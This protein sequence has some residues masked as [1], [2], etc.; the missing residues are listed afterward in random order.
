MT[1]Y[2]EMPVGVGSNFLLEVALVQSGADIYEQDVFMENMSELVTEL[3]QQNPYIG[4]K[5]VMDV[6]EP[7]T[8]ISL[9]DGSETL[10]H[11]SGDPVVCT[12]IDFSPDINDVNGILCADLAVEVAFESAYLKGFAAKIKA[13]AIRNMELEEISHPLVDEL[14]SFRQAVE[15]FVEAKRQ[16]PAADFDDYVDE[17]VADIEARSTVMQAEVELLI[18]DIAEIDLRRLEFLPYWVDQDDDESE[19]S[20]DDL[21]ITNDFRGIVKGRVV[22][23]QAIDDGDESVGLEVI[24]ALDPDNNLS[25]DPTYRYALIAVS[26]IS[27]GR[28]LSGPC[29]N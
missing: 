19:I 13:E 28:I 3:G 1:A 12:V 4:R 26:D 29:C 16:Y 25:D 14:R 5:V 22:G 10:L 7:F 2:E 18:A 27:W 6:I 24:L 20:I 15:S 17:A 8:L 11:S 23:F 9:A 21:R